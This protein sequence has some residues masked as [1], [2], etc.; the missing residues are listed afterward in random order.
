MLKS[1]QSRL[2]VSYVAIIVLVLVSF[3]VAIT[4]SL[5]TN[6]YVYRNTIAQMHA[7]LADLVF[8]AGDAAFTS[9]NQDLGQLLESSVEQNGYRFL[10]I[11]PDK[12]ILADTIHD[13][14]LIL[15]RLRS[16]TLITSDEAI[17]G[18][19]RD[20]KL[21]VWLYAGYRLANGNWLVAAVPRPRLV[22][23]NIMRDEVTG[24]LVLTGIGALLAGTLLAVWMAHQISSPLRKLSWRP[25]R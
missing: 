22:F 4:I 1:L 25:I 19:I 9:Q 13:S 18:F 11:T 20:T 3:T 6:P 24:P 8:Q 2:W 21:H 7:A 10:V 23:F 12:R 16:K 15:A 17:A 14:N 5:F